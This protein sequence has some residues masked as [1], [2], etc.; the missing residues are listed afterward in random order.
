MKN[1]NQITEF[2]LGGHSIHDGTHLTVYYKSGRQKTYYSKG[3]LP[4]SV[5][6]FLTDE[7]TISETTYIHDDV[8]NLTHK[9]IKYLPANR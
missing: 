9:R 7:S 3:I 2:V 6:E 4:M 5:V 1:I 8:N